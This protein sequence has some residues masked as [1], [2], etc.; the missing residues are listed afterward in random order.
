MKHA[1]ETRHIWCRNHTYLGT[2]GVLSRSL[3]PFPRAAES[4]S[5]RPPGVPQEPSGSLLPPTIKS[6]ARISHTVN[7]HPSPTDLQDLKDLKP[8][9]ETQNSTNSFR[10]F[11]RGPS[12]EQ[13]QQQEYYLPHWSANVIPQFVHFF[14]AWV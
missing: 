6:W 3:S 7:D 2:M 10:R 11:L 14:C 9:C 13:K 5:P 1:P 8:R 12:H 4:G